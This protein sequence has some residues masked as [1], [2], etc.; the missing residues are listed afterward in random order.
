MRFEVFTIFPDVFTPYIHTSIIQR[1]VTQEIIQIHI[2]NIRD[3]AEDKHQ[4]TDDTP[5][6]GG[7][8]MVMK[9]EPI[10]A[11]VE[12]VLS[13][14]PSC[15]VILMSPQGEQLTHHLAEDLGKYERLGII[16]GRYEGVDERVRAHLIT[17]EISIGDYVLSGGELPALVLIEAV[18]RLLPGAL[19]D[20]NGAKNDSFASGLL[21]HPHYT[22]PAEFRGWP[23]P[24]VLL[25]GNHKE[26]A[27][28]RR[29]KSLART[30]MERP[31]LLSRLELEK[32]D[33]QMLE[34]IQREPGEIE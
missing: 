2:H 6:G 4:T 27:R 15:P 9:P 18:T 26:I 12:A 19:G 14:P 28:W 20:P 29:K 17:N 21:E 10:F 3:W 23:V 32:S 33:Q 11:A 1:A 30:L 7:G 13:E 25:S 22:R 24:E 8:G 31:D 5:F 34:E 16:C